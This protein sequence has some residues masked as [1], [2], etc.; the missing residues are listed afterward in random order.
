M[1][2]LRDNQKPNLFSNTNQKSHQIIALSHFLINY[3]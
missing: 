1:P 2:N 3:D